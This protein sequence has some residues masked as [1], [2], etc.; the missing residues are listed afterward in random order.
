MKK[1]GLSVI[2]A[3]ALMGSAEGMK[4]KHKAAP[5][6]ENLQVGDL[7]FSGNVQ[8]MCMSGKQTGKAGHLSLSCEL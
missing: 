6:L 1:A 7:I 8:M 2:L 3:M 5:S 4:M